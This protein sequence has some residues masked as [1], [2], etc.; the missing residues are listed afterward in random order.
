MVKNKGIQFFMEN[1]KIKRKKDKK[2]LTF[3]SG[4]LNPRFSMIFQPMIWIFM[5]S[6][7]GEIK[8]KQASKRDRT[9]NEMFIA[10][11][12]CKFS[13]RSVVKAE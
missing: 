5:E 13:K 6:E 9:L 3:R 11:I 8:S 4:D 7:E 1:L 2:F 12:I 10:R